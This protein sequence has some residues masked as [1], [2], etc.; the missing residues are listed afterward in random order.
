[1]G[2]LA[3][4]QAKVAAAKVR[5]PGFAPEITVQPPNITNQPNMFSG[6]QVS[7][8]A[9]GAEPLSYQWRLKGTNVPG[10]TARTLQRAGVTPEDAGG[11]D[12]VVSNS[13]GAVTSRVYQVTV[14]TPVNWTKSPTSQLVLLNQATLTGTNILPADCTASALAGKTL[15]CTIT[16]AATGWPA[17]GQFDF[18]M[19]T[20]TQFG[21]SYEFPSGGVFG[22]QAN[23]Y[24]L[25]FNA[26]GAVYLFLNK[27]PNSA[28][29]S[30]IH[31]YSGGYY[32]LEPSS[33][34]Q[35]ITSPGTYVISGG[36]NTA[37]FTVA[38]NTG[39]GVSSVTYQWQKD[40]VD[41][42]GATS[43]TLTID[44]VT[45][46]EA[47][48]YRCVVTVHDATG[49]LAYAVPSAEAPLRVVTSVQ[50]PPAGYTLAPGGTTMTITWAPG[51]VLQSTPSLSPPA[52]N[53]IATSGPFTATTTSGEG[54]F[55]VV[56][57]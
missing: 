53:T 37:S 1:V 32:F 57:E 33:N 24:T 30:I 13:Y 7:L 18:K 21:G 51:Y 22:Y 20:L 8:T 16:N 43:A 40:G 41:L 31:F 49:T 54:Y 39:S 23:T 47:G 36:A 25:Y 34:P 45:V 28:S 35:K 46:T 10:A 56:P 19:T 17:S 42:P 52:W 29:T 38:L 3:T 6:F 14:S 15:T 26:V 48:L 2:Y 11:Y 55:R 44:P 5:A 12:C 50:M 4:N 9:V 27:F